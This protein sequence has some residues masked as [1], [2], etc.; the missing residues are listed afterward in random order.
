MKETWGILFAFAVTAL[1]IFLWGRLFVNM[2]M[3]PAR[4][5]V[6]I[7]VIAILIALLAI[8][9]S[10]LG[11]LSWALKCCSTQSRVLGPG[12]VW[13]LF[14]PIFNVFLGFFFVWAIN[15]SLQNEFKLLNS[16]DHPAAK[17]WAGLICS[18]CTL[19]SLVTA[20]TLQVSIWWFGLVLGAIQ[21]AAW[22]T[23]W[24]AIS[25]CGNYLGVKNKVAL[26]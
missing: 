1:S 18:I 7:L 10:F 17:P 19:T 23:Y 26:I 16:I 15:K 4:A 2:I 22:I 3:H 9:C 5:A 8:Y 13:W 12:T 21:L 20:E 6:I 14:I 25:K 24:R 11:A